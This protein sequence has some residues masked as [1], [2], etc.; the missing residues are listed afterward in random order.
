MSQQAYTAIIELL[1]T[2]ACIAVLG[3]V[4]VAAVILAAWA[5]DLKEKGI[6]LR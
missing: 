3:P 1:S 2:V 4:A 6:K 5:Q